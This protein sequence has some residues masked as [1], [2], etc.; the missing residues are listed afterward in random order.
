MGGAWRGGTQRSTVM[1]SVLSVVRAPREVT[2]AMSAVAWVGVITKL[3]LG[4][5]TKTTCR[6]RIGMGTGPG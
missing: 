4:T 1:P 5:N 2:W 6:D 3:S